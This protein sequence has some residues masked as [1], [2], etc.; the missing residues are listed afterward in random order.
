MDVQARPSCRTHPYPASEWLAVVAS[1]DPSHSCSH[2][3]A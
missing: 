1:A 3:G 2:T